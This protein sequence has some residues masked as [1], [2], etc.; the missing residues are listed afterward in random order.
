MVVN[1]RLARVL[2]LGIL[3][4]LVCVRLRRMVVLMAVR[5]RQMDPFLARVLIVRDVPMLVRVN[6][7][8]VPMLLRHGDTSMETN[9]DGKASLTV[10]KEREGDMKKAES[11]TGI[12][13]VRTVA[14]PVRN[15]DQ[16]LEFYL[17]KLGFEKRMDATFGANQRW[18]EVAPAGAS[19]T[20]ALVRPPE[21]APIGVDTGIRLTTE[22]AEAEH[23]ALQA[24]GVNVDEMLR[25]GGPVPP[26][27]EFRDPDGNKFV[28][29][30]SM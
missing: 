16:A 26:M 2:L 21:G 10:K 28:L 5:R 13:Q 24:R 8:L 27:F 6:E 23:A 15:Q 3:M 17:G 20:I 9:D 1:M 12:K 22:D 30:E 29:V 11:A 4:G 25:F 19:T 14:V 18:V 7:T